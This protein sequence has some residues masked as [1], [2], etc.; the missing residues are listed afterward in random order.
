M[1]QILVAV[2]ILMMFVSPAHAA[3]KPNDQAPLFVLSDVAGREYSLGGMLASSE[4][5]K[6]SGVVLSF[7]A[8]WCAP[9]RKELPLLDSMTDELSKQGIRV[10]LVNVKEDV[11]VISALLNELHVRKPIVLAD[12]QGSIA[13]RYMLRY[14]PTTF[15]IGADGTIK[16]IIF[17]EIKG[18]Q[19]LRDSIKK[20]V[21]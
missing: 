15:F 12:R 11:P 10:L 4:K 1:K 18:V 19:E 6:T 5:E 3:L 13:E 20:L 21:K 17:G 9:C 16:D 7:F 14:F 2:A 8:S